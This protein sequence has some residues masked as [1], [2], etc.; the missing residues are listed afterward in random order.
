MHYSIALDGPAGVGKSTIAR[1][2]AEKLHFVYID[3]GAMYRALGVYFLEEGLS[4][5]DESA[6]EAALPK[7]DCSIR[8]QKG[9]QHVLLNERDVTKELRTEEVSAM[10]SV[11]S[12]YQA[13][14]AKL[15]A[16]QRALAASENVIMDGRDIGTVVLP[17]AVLKIFLTAD[18][19]VRAKRRYDQLAAQGKLGTLKLSEIEADMEARDYRDMHRENA[20][21]RAAEDAVVVDSSNLSAAEVECRILELLLART[22]DMDVRVW[23]KKAIDGLKSEA[24]E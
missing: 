8:Y 5:S 19:H 11:T 15:T 14:R 22:E 7:I 20:P 17:D 18:S 3:T 10:A 9:E 12:Q 6:I 4:A 2:L 16:L 23:T 13:V 1:A 21:L 24:A